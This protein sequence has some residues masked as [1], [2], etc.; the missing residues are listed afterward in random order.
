MSS[1]FSS[2]TSTSSSSPLSIEVDANDVLRLVLQFLREQGLSSTAQTLQSESGIVCNT[3]DNPTAFVQEII[4][5]NWSMVLQT[6]QSL[7]LDASTLIN[8]YELIILECIESKDTE[9][10]Q[11]LLTSTPILVLK[12]TEPSRYQRIVRFVSSFSSSSLSSSSHGFFI[13]P[14]ELYNDGLT[15]EKRRG[16]IAKDILEQTTNIL[17]SRLLS[18]LGQ[19]IKWQ[20]HT[21]TLTTKTDDTTSIPSVAQR[22]NTV[23]RTVDLIQSTGPQQITAPALLE[24]LSLSSSIASASSSALLTRIRTK[25]DD[26]ICLT[27]SGIL[28]KFGVSAKPQV[29]LFTPDGSSFI[30]GSYDGII[31]IY[32]PL[33]GKLRSDLEYQAKDECLLHDE[34]ITSLGISLDSEF[35]V[36]GSRDGMIKVWKISSGECIRKFPNAHGT[37]DY[38]SNTGSSSTASNSY[39]VPCVQFS[40]DSTQIVSGS[41]DGTVRIF[42]LRSGKSMKEFRGHTAVISSCLWLAD[43]T[44]LVTSS[45]DGTVRVW[46]IK[47]CECTHVWKLPQIV[48][49]ADTPLMHMVTVPRNLDQII[50]VS[51]SPRLYLL[52]LS[53]GQVLRTY[54][55]GK[56][57]NVAD[58]RYATL[59]SSGKWLYGVAE[60]GSI[61]IFN[62]A[63]GNLET[64]TSSFSSSTGITTTTTGEGG[65]NPWHNRTILGVAHHPHQNRIATWSDD[66]TVKMWLPNTK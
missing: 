10:A 9:L 6:C 53:T 40:R 29:C 2:T 41:T 30:T 27:Y 63:N 56:E 28:L 47:T 1:S 23:S 37:N 54:T 51:R 50:V 4:N 24:A 59:S 22:T 21:G 66:G 7:R 61:Y 16:T 20:I 39:G 60:D 13:D 49:T 64:N 33:T 26:Q 52:S 31:E 35:L 14:M 55:H 38:T 25:E 57:P 42:G 17:P 32:N 48:A 36:S 58:F 3:L 46:D 65:I 5:G 44:R 45:Y 15:K 12:Q 34:G 43:N 18:L 62:F 11:T 8:L 19:A